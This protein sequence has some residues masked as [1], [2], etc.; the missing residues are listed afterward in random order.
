MLLKVRQFIEVVSGADTKYQCEV[1]P[2][3]PRRSVIMGEAMETDCGPELT[4]GMTNG[5][6]ADPVQLD[7]IRGSKLERILDCG[8]KLHAWHGRLTDE[9]TI[10]DQYKLVICPNIIFLTVLLVSLSTR[11]QHCA[12]W[13]TG[14]MGLSNRSKIAKTLESDVY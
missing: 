6:K 13:S 11:K 2:E 3:P 10:C 4:N 1:E 8:R 5:H 9:N 14:P 12:T 7:E